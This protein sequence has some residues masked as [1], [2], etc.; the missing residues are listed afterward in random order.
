MIRYHDEETFYSM[1]VK[2]VHDRLN[3]DITEGAGGSFTGQ[4]EVTG[5]DRFH[6]TGDLLLRV[7]VREPV[8]FVRVHQR[9]VPGVGLVHRD[10]HPGATG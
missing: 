9:S 2:A 10:V 4:A 7:R 6:M 1:F 8:E 5:L 3:H